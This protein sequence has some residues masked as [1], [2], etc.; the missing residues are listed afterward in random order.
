MTGE[1][2]VL[3]R[4]AG[5]CLISTFHIRRAKRYSLAAQLSKYIAACFTWDLDRNHEQTDA[6]AEIA[7]LCHEQSWQRAVW[8]IK[9]GLQIRD[10]TSIDNEVALQ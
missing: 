3:F 9:Q 5:V 10:R 1:A 7:Q 8:H 6:L 2:L 4:R